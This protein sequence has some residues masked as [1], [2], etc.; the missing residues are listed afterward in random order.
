M[1]EGRLAVI[2]VDVERMRL[3][4]DDHTDMATD[5]VADG[6]VQRPLANY[7]AAA[8]AASTS[9]WGVCGSMSKGVSWS[10]R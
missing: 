2:F 7:R 10:V 4:M 8:K 6:A 5:M 3:S 1:S 9:K